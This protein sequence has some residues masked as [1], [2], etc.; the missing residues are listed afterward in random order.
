MGDKWK[1]NY[2]CGCQ[3]EGHDLGDPTPEHCPSHGEPKRLLGFPMVEIPGCPSCARFAAKRKD[4]EGLAKVIYYLDPLYEF[5]YS[6]NIA[7]W[8]T[9][10]DSDKKESYKIADAAFR[11]MEE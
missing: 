7:K 6:R 10:V 5:P 4:R 1:V 3:F 2:P 9:L 11:W 8:E